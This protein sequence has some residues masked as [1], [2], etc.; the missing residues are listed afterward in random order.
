MP[1]R[2]DF[3]RLDLMDALDLAILIELEAK[4]RY[5][6]FSEQLGYRRAGDASEIF[7][8]L[9]RNEV[10]HAADLQSQ[11]LAQFGDTPSRVSTTDLFDVEAPDVGTLRVGMSPLRALQIALSAEQ[12]AFQFY[13]EALVY[14][15]APDVR[16]TFEELREEEWEHVRLVGA[17]IAGLPAGSD[18]E[19][20]GEDDEPDM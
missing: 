11:R 14:I 19:D 5:E 13:D 8:S 15:T 3:A 9:A 10:K 7:R 20:L 2:I 4:E 12:K 6:T 16:R 17:A 1:A 18:E